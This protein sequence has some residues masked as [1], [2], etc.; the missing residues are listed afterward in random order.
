MGAF[1]YMNPHTI[2]P[3]AGK[4]LVEIVEVLGGKTKG[5]IHLPE[6][7]QDHMGKDTFYGRVLKVGPPPDLAHYKSGPGPGWDVRKNTTGTPWPKEVME[8]FQEGSI[9]VFPRDVPMVFVWEE[10]RYAL[11]LVHEAIISIDGDSFDPDEFRV[12]PWIPQKIEQ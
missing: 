1:D 8:L 11:C 9:I 5:G 10:K 3:L 2:V 6:A 7:Y 12:M 4:V